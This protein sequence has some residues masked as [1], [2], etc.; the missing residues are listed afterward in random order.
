M[1]ID[2]LL[3]QVPKELGSSSS[4]DTGKIKSPTPIKVTV[5]NSEPLPNIQQ[6]PLKPEILKGIRPIVQESLEIGLIIPCTSPC[7]SPILGVCKPDGKS[8]RFVEHLRAVKN[9]V[10]P[11]CPV[12]PNPHTSLS[13]IPA[14]S[15]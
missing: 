5:D 2:D 1:K 11:Q 15:S 7:N 6:Y 9:I 3:L 14:E 8:W 12:V 4:S 10:I 13:A